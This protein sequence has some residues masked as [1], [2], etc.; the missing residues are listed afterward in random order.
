M[1][2][3]AEAVVREVT[4]ELPGSTEAWD[5]LEQLKVAQGDYEGVLEVRRERLSV[6]PAGPEAIGDVVAPS[7]GGLAAPELEELRSRLSEE[8]EVGYWRWRLEDLR[9][10]REQGE[11]VSSV[12]LAR[13]S[14][15]LGETEQALDHLEEASATR[16]RNLVSLWTDPAWDGLRT[17]PRFRKVLSQVRTGRAPEGMR[18]GGRLR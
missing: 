1:L 18:P 16:D 7:S 9:I 15:G 4:Q 14:L 12:E 2:E 13:A 8:G 6:A 17:N 11:R 3:Q 10:R 5:A